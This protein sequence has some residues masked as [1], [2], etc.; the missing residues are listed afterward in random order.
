MQLVLGTAQW[1]LAY[2][3]A[4]RGRPA[5][6]A[7]VV[8]ILQ[9]AQEAGVR[10]IDTAQAYGDIEARLPGLLPRSVEWRVTTKIPALPGALQTGE[11]GAWV[12]RAV[13]TSVARLGD[14]L[15]AILLHDTSA[16]EDGSRAAAAWDTLQN[17][18][19]AH[20]LAPGV[21]VYSPAELAALCERWPI[22]QAQLPAN[23]L[24]QRLRDREPFPTNVVRHLRSVF[25]QGLLLLDEVAPRLPAA[26]SALRRWRAWCAEHSMTPACAALSV[27]RSLDPG[28]TGLV[29][30][31]ER[32]SQLAGVLEAWRMSRPMPAPELRCDAPEVIDP[33]QWKIA[34]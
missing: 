23:A 19:A 25:L 12:G 27:A 22:R 2:G 24:D 32:E 15:E 3:I 13:A 21:S 29:I 30:G 8:S 20:H 16:L 28:A 10:R 5:T 7:E 14:R 18:C 1:G 34:T 11:I 33:R 26:A 4:G 9:T 31:V 17:A 6:D